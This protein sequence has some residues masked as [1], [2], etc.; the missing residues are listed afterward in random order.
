MPERERCLNSVKYRSVKTVRRGCKVNTGEIRFAKFA[1]G[2]RRGTEIAKRLY[3]KDSGCIKFLELLQ[4][5]LACLR[6]EG[7][8]KLESRLDIMPASRWKAVVAPRT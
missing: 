1:G 5:N 4:G 3:K 7:Y 8:L 6:S 2:W